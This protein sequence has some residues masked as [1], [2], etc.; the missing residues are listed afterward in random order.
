M[1]TIAYIDDTVAAAKK[2]ADDTAVK[3]WGQT[4]FENGKPKAVSGA[5]SGITTAT[6]NLYYDRTSDGGNSWNNGYGAYNVEIA[7]NNAQTPLLLAYRAGSTP[8]AT[9]ANRLFAMEL[10]NTADRLRMAFG[11]ADKFTFY[12]DGLFVAKKAIQIGSITLTDKNGYLEIGSTVVATGDVQ[13]FGAS[14]TS[15]SGSGGAAAFNI[16]NSWTG[17]YDGTY[18]LGAGL[19]KELY[20]NKANKATTLSGY[21]ITDAYT[22]SEADGRYVSAVGIDVNS[23]HLTVTKNN[24]TSNL[25]IPYATR[26]RYQNVIDVRD[27]DRLPNYFEDYALT[28]W[29]NQTG[30]PRSDWYSGLTM[31]GW[32]K[33]TYATWQIAANATSSLPD[34]NLYFRVGLGT[35]WESWQKVLTDANYD[36]ILDTHYYTESEA[37]GRFAKLAS[38]NNLV[39]SSNEITMIPAGYNNDILFNHRAVGGTGKIGTYHMCN[40]NNGN[41]GNYA[42]VAANGFIK[43]G[44]SNDYLLLGGGGHK[45]LSDLATASALSSGLAGKVSKAGDTMTGLLHIT[46]NGQTLDLGSRNSSLAHFET[47]APSGFYFN[48]NVAVAGEIYAGSSYN[49]KVWHQGNDGPGSGLDADLLDGKHNGAVT[50]KDL[51]VTTPTTIGVTVSV[52]KQNML[53]AV[54]GSVFGNVAKVGADL[55]RNWS[56]NSHTTAASSSYSVINVTPQYDGSSYGQYLLFHY[57]SLNPKVIGRN[58]GEWTSMKTIA[59]IDD[60]VAAAKKW[61]TARSFSIADHSDKQRGTSVNV[62]GSADVVLKMPSAAEFTGLTVTG[63]SATN[64]TIANLYATSEEVRNYLRFRNAGTATSYTTLEAFANGNLRVNGY[65]GSSTSAIA[66]FEAANARLSL[67]KLYVGTQLTFADEAGVYGN[68]SMIK[69]GSKLYLDKANDVW[70]MYD[71]SLGVIVASHTIVSKGDIQ[72]FKTA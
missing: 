47:T 35:A 38:P 10:L 29:F 6:A 7:N 3:A 8:S 48:K 27:A 22:K 12:K 9:G 23:N 18:A 15:G 59:Y 13:A 25:T 62:N 57:G 66:T 21:G 65:N 54:K 26:S 14:S 71:R 39:H 64:A 52:A 53:N 58:N 34:K 2:L 43:G 17:T 72:A 24:V 5:M 20:Q 50:A 1:K 60:T 28:A 45:A 69:A 33:G 63:I 37:D 19:G 30:M 49:Q 61:A 16:L 31:Q 70:V 68:I 42:N 41:N 44:S 40:G 11:G 4:F 56:T 55:I 51:T 36:S 32:S 67:F 46:I